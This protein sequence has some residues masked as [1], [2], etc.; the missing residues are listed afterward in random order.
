MREHWMVLF[1]QL[2]RVFFESKLKSRRGGNVHNNATRENFKRQWRLLGRIL[3]NG[4]KH[5][6]ADDGVIAKSESSRIQ[7]FPTDSTNAFIII[8]VKLRTL[9]CVIR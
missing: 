5:A 3:Q 6:D 9:M 7:V 8:I 1:E 4:K 2:T